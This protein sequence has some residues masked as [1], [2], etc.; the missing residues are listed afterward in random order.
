[1]PHRQR[2]DG[3]GVDTAGQERTYG[4][5]GAHM[6]GDR[7]FERC[8]DL[9]V[10]GGLAARRERAHTERR[11]EVAGRHRT[12]TRPHDRVTTR[13]QPP[14]AGVQCFRFRN[15]L[16]HGVVLECAMVERFVEPE[17]GEQ[18]QQALLLA[19][20]RCT[21]GP[22]GQ[23]QRF[24]TERVAGEEQF[25]AARIPDREGEHPAQPAHRI[26]TPVVERRHDGLAVALGGEH[27]L[28]AELGRVIA[29]QFF[30]QFQI[31]VD[32]AVEGERVAL[33]VVGRPP[34]QRLMRMFDIDDRE[35][36]EA[37]DQL[38]VV[39]GAALI[40]PPVPHTVQGVVHPFHCF[41]RCGIGRQKSEQ[42]THCGANLVSSGRGSAPRD[43]G[44]AG[45]S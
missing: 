6:L 16:Q 4:D 40:R 8:R 45:E 9:G 13:F 28:F 27:G 43:A 38:V 14:D 22:G 21:T 15:V 12:L 3:G 34:A 17:I 5:I 29:G 37:E 19:A 20:E 30:A 24:D 44:A 25:P 10:P 39:P 42:S 33:G 2:C 7:I 41:R 26:G 1:M 32:L 35:P 18:F 11:N 23:E 31:V 36:V